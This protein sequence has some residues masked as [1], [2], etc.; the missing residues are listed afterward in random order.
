MIKVDLKGLCNNT[1]FNTTQ[2]PQ[3]KLSVS[4]FITEILNKNHCNEWDEATLHRYLASNSNGIAKLGQGGFLKEDIKNIIERWEFLDSHLKAIAKSQEIP[5]WE[6]YNEVRKIVRSC[7]QKNMKIATNRMLAGIQ[8]LILCSEVDIRRINKLVAYIH[9]YTTTIIPPYN[10]D[11]WEQASYTLLH[12][13][14]KLF[15]DYDKMSFC[16][17]PWKLLDWFDDKYGEGKI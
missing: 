4:L 13:F 12:E 1:F 3:Y 7:T 6:E 8:P 17:L 5:L 10:K 16:S 9:K 2:Y 11:N 14:H 15:P